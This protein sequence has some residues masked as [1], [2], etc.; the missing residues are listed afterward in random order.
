MWANPVDSH[1]DNELRRT[2]LD[3]LLRF[4][5]FKTLMIKSKTNVDCHLSDVTAG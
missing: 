4:V 3:S 1:S 5:T 2:E